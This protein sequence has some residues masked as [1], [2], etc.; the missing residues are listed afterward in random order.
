MLR[1]CAVKLPAIELTEFWSSHF[2]GAGDARHVGL[3]TEATSSVP[4]SRATRAR[5]PAKRLSWSTIVFSVSFNCTS[6]RARR[7]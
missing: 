7:P 3:A 2:Q 6:R 5:S 1:T 4:T